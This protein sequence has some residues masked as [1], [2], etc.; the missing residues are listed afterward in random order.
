MTGRCQPQGFGEGLCANSVGICTQL[1]LKPVTGNAGRYTFPRG[2]RTTGLERWAGDPV[3]GLCAEPTRGLGPCVLTCRAVGPQQRS[4]NHRIPRNL[5][6]SNPRPPQPFSWDP[7]S[8]SPWEGASRAP[9]C[10]RCL[11]QCRVHPQTIPDHT[12]ERFRFLST[13]QNKTNFCKNPY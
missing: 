10:H 9:T 13:I 12:E 2:E 6:K 3:Q 5:P 4:R 7:P 11:L 8:L 1:T